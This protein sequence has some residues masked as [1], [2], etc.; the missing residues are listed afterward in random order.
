MR[1]I[2]LIVILLTTCNVFS[3]TLYLKKLHITDSIYAPARI[4]AGEYY[5][6][7]IPFSSGGGDVYLGNRQTFAARNVFSDTLQADGKTLIDDAKITSQL[8]VTGDVTS[9][10]NFLQG[11]DTKIGTIDNYGFVL[12]TADT[13]RLVIDSL[14]YAT[15]NKSLTVGTYLL[16]IDSIQTTSLLGSTLYLG[17][18]GGKIIFRGYNSEISESINQLKYIS[19]QHNFLT[20]GGY[21]FIANLDS[22]TGMNLIY[23]DYYKNGVLLFDSSK[24]ARTE[25]SISEL[26][27][28]VVTFA[29]AVYFSAAAT[30]NS[31]LTVVGDFIPTWTKNNSTRAADQYEK[32]KIVGFKCASS[33]SSTTTAAHGITDWR[34]I[35]SWTVLVRDS[36]AKISYSTGANVQYAAIDSLNCSQYV[37]GT[38]SAITSDSIFFRIV[39]TDFNR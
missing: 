10:L 34:T 19:R 15:F 37:C 36:A 25:S 1:K 32:T 27:N 16:A 7:G 9:D 22:S 5:K 39:Y 4:N 3:Q 21:N 33:V 14:G 12:K 6:N 28:S 31:T 20:K 23:G 17:G 26:F 38:C 24:F 11:M 2:F 13:N 18:A 30:F 29:S 35:K 8:K